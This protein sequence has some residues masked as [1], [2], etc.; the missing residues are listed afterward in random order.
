V[1]E[2]R[3]RGLLAGLTELRLTEQRTSDPAMFGRLGV[4]DP[5]SATSTA[6]LL[7]V[8]DAS[9]KPVLSVIVGHRRVR[10]Q[11]NAPEEVY[12]RRPDENRSWLAEGKS[13]TTGSR[14]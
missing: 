1:Q 12:V 3:L 10:S 14:P 11:A 6:N 5:N 4:D 8:L 9:Q 2:S 13:P 7:R